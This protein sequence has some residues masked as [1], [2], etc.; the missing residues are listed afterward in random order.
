MKLYLVFR[1]DIV[2]GT[3]VDLDAETDELIGIFSEPALAAN[4]IRD[5]VSKINALDGEDEHDWLETHDA[6]G[7]VIEAST[8]GMRIRV[9]EATL[10]AMEWEL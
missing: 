10:D 8:D 2:P 7:H 9:Q 1:S 3:P 4:A 6:V 5:A